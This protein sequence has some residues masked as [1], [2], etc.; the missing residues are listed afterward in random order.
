VSL[1]DAQIKNLT[2]RLDRIV[3]SGGGI[4]GGGAQIVVGDQ[5]VNV[6]GWQQFSALQQFGQRPVG[7]ELGIEI[8][9]FGNWTSNE[10]T[11]DLSFAVWQNVTTRFGEAKVN[12][13]IMNNGAQFAYR[14]LCTV[15][16]ISGNQLAMHTS[17]TVS[18]TVAQYP[19]GV[20]GIDP[21]AAHDH[22]NQTHRT[23]LAAAEGHAIPS[24]VGGI[25]PITLG[26]GV[27][28]QAAP[29]SINRSRTKFFDGG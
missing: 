3:A 20:G 7:Y 15:T 5:T 24:F 25:F 10:G 26:I 6:A 16:V 18:G 23:L 22:A 12:G 8:S 13:R 14:V 2:D 19:T 4:G 29:G 21:G 28:W 17:V 11:G 27:A 9:G 1:G